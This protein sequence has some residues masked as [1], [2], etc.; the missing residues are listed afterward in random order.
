MRHMHTPAADLPHQQ[1][2]KRCGVRFDEKKVRSR[3]GVVRSCAHLEQRIHIRCAVIVLKHAGLEL[4][5]RHSALEALS[6]RQCRFG[7]K[8]RGLVSWTFEKATLASHDRTLCAPWSQ[9]CG[10]IPCLA[11]T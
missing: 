3:N 11:M 8:G 10:A 5:L 7:V 6:G 9:T 2:L 1:L 4:I